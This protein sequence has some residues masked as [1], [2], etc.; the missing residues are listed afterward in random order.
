MINIYE[1]AGLQRAKASFRIVL[2]SLRFLLW[3]PVLLINFH[4]LKLAD[5]IHRLILSGAN[6][7]CKSPTEGNEGNEDSV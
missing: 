5:G 6:Q 1:C 3:N 2:H 4:E 7:P